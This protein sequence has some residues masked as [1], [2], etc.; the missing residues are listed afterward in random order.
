V[1]LKGT[2]LR[3]SNFCGSWISDSINAPLFSPESK[4]FSIDK[5]QKISSED[6][7]NIT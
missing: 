5:L 3:N 2:Y 7:L 6:A 4:V 1:P